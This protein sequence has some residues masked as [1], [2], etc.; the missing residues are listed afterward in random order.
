MNLREDKGWSYGSRTLF[1]NAK[2]Q[3]PFLVRAPVQRN[4]TGDS[5]VE[6]IRELK[7]IQSSNPIT[8]EEM[9]RTISSATRGLPGQFQTASAVLNSLIT[10]AR[11]GRPLNY[12]ASLTERY[13]SLQLEDLQSAAGEII[14]PNGL[15]WV[16]VGDLN[17]IRGQVEPLNIAPLEIWSVDGVPVE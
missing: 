17:E 2:A 8:E 4:R 9:S 12:A 7:T 16:V 14:R 13:E 10:S 11:Y 15:T 6:L 3:R 1:Q 5:L